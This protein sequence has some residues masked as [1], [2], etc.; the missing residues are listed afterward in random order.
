MADI[1]ASMDKAWCKCG[2]GATCW[3]AGMGS[4]PSD[5]GKR[6]MWEGANVDN[7]RG[8]CVCVGGHSHAKSGDEQARFEG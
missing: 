8:V 2:G 6:W 5:V 7:K 1:W 4:Q 3:Q